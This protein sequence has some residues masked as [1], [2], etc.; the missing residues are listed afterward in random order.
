MS[1]KLISRMSTPDLSPR[2][3]VHDN[4]VDLHIAANLSFFMNRLN[5]SIFIV[6]L[7]AKISWS[8]QCHVHSNL[9]L[10][11]IFT[12]T[13]IKKQ[14]ELIVRNEKKECESRKNREPTCVL[15]VYGLI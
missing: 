5:T 2:L 9:Q 3:Q 14:F 10:A 4:Q 13:S 12:K 8:R 15:H 7:F 11:D 1:N 6:I